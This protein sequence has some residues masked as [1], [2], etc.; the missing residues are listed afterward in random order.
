MTAGWQ[1]LGLVFSPSGHGWM[2]SHAQ[3]PFPESLGHG[4][5]RV[6]FAARDAQNRARGGWF[7]FDIRDP[8]RVLAVSAEPTLELGDLGAFDDCGVMPNSI[9]QRDGRRFMY[10]TGWS[11]AVEVPFSFHI[12]LAVSDDGGL[13]YVRASRAPV[14]GRNHHD[15]FIT[16]APYVL[17]E[18]DMFKM[19]YISATKWE[20]ESEAAKPKHYYTVK[21]AESHDG[22]TWTCS[23]H[24]CL[25]YRPDEYAIAR[26][27]VRRDAAGYEMWFTYRGGADTYRVG[28]ASSRD[29]VHWVR[30]DEPLGVDVSADGWDQEMICY[31]HPLVWAGRHY[32]LYNGNAYGATGIGLAILE[33]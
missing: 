6:H 20:R 12:G 4:K 16:G 13:S 25:D 8:G 3:N 32:A 1:K 18:G 5:Y 31:A 10:Y 21:Y 28:T 7:D 2:R 33:P 27:V 24:L 9:V 14:L 22:V 17:V 15:P 30:A 23:D 11:K 29:G 26:P 19:W